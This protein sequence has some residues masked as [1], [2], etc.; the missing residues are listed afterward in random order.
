MIGSRDIK[1]VGR[2][3]QNS[4]TKGPHC[5]K[6]FALESIYCLYKN[7]IFITN[8]KKTRRHSEDL[9]DD[10]SFMCCAQVILSTAAGFTC[11]SVCGCWNMTG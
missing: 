10:I 11:L 3:K 8:Q 5:N 9:A 4:E 1:I 7:H 2:E 6:I